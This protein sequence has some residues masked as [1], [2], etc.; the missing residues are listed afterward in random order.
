VLVLPGHLECCTKPVLNWI[1]KNLGTETRV[2]L[3]FQY[4]PEWRA[5]EIPELRRSLTEDERKRAIQL[6]EKA[7]LKNFIT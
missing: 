1:A 5:H 3:M 2:N 6:A 4:K 7:G